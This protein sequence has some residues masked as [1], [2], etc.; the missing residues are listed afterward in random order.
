MYGDKA[1]IEIERKFLIKD[2][3]W[4]NEIGDSTKVRQGFLSIDQKATVRVR[5][6]LDLG[7]ITVKGITEGISRSEFEYEIPKVDADEMLE[8]LCLG[9]V[10]EKVRHRILRDD[11][12]WEIDEFLGGNMGLILAELEL[13]SEDQDFERPSWLGEE[14]SYD[15]RYF[16]AY[17][18]TKPHSEW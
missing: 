15:P 17:M 6:V 18:A 11:L 14:V 7:V 5:R 1:R 12:V 4:R 3:S 2:E 10:I 8:T 9:T 13:R 16:N